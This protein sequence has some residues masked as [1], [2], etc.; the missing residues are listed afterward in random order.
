MYSNAHSEGPLPGVVSARWKRCGKPGCRCQAGKLH[1]PYYLRRWREGGR[2]RSQYLDRDDVEKVREQCQQE[3]QIRAGLRRARQQALGEIR[4]LIQ[5][6]R[7]TEATW[8][9]QR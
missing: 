2:Q 3:Q 1:G 7:D 9:P 6:T 5:T 4:E 8:K